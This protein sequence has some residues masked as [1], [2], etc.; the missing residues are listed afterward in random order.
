MNSE[1]LSK[2]LSLG[3]LLGWQDVKQ[4]YRRSS[5]GPFWITAG[6][7]VQVG[8][9]GLVFG[10]I[11]RQPLSEYL[12]FLATSIVLWGL[13]S[14][15]ITDGCNSF[16]TA[17]SII[18]QRQVPIYVFILRT[19]WKQITIFAH[20]L[21]IVPFVFLI[22]LQ[23]FSWPLL[24]FVPGL[25][26]AIANLTWMAYLLAIVSARYRDVPQV[27]TSAMTILYF[28]S[29]VIWKPEVIPADVAHL[30]LGLNPLYHILQI[31]RLPILGGLPTLENW[32]LSLAFAAVGGCSAY[33][34][35]KKFKNKIAYW[36]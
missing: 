33:L 31:V 30:L 18:K 10:L 22:V 17:E 28:V 5:L 13:I 1:T 27:V 20:N 7:G 23:G 15:V 35:S 29:P 26:L 19:V 34:A 6:M 2:N 25:V 36:V 3:L 16:I 4:A 21:V 32:L 12:P 9:M 14:S 8:A 24:L 11:F